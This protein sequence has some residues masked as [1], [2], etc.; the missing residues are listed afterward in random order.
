MCSDRECQPLRTL[1]EVQ[2]WFP[3]KYKF[4]KPIKLHEHKFYHGSKVIVCHDMKGGYQE[5]R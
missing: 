2:Q 4:E 5:D 3:K 1:E